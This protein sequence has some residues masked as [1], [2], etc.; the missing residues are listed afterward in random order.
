LYH[1]WVYPAR[2]RSIVAGAWPKQVYQGLRKVPWMGKLAR[3]IRGD[4][5]EGSK[6][7]SRRDALAQED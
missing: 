7:Q 2:P 5:K 1:L 3:A 6:V 4:S